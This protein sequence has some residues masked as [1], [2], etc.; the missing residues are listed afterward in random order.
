MTMDLQEA[1]DQGFDAIKGY[2]D[3]SFDGFAKQID[4]I[5]ARLDLVEQGGVKY[6]GTY[7]RASPYKR[8]SVVT[9]QGSMWTALAD[10]PEGVVPGMSASL[11]HL[12]AKGGKA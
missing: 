12:S 3:R 2:V 10:V 9:H 7:Q 4:A 6:L 11:W 1:F 8:G 5:R